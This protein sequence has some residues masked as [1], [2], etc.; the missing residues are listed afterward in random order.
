MALKEKFTH[1]HNSVVDMIR[2][3]VSHSECINVKLLFEEE[4]AEFFTVVVKGGTQHN[5]FNTYA[6]SYVHNHNVDDGKI[7]L[8][9]NVHLS[10]A[11]LQCE[12]KTNRTKCSKYNVTNTRTLLETCSR[13]IGVKTPY[14]LK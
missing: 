5:V 11:K 8:M 4:H 13:L 3:K 9:S 1:L 2:N 14:N 7:K 12:T 6:H 10:V